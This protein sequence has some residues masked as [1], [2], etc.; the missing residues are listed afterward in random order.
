MI[1]T[2]TPVCQ[3]GYT[4]VRGTVVAQH[5]DDLYT[6]AW[7]SVGKSGTLTWHSHE[8]RQDFWTADDEMA[9]RSL[10]AGKR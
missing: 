9:A 6:V 1:D 5:G 8:R 2:G 7:Q 3:A 4:T 10:E